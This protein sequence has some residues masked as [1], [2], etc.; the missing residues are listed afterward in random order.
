MIAEAHLRRHLT[1][2]ARSEAERAADRRQKRP[3]HVN[4]EFDIQGSRTCPSGPMCEWLGEP[5]PHLLGLKMSSQIEPAPLTYPPAVVG[6]N[7]DSVA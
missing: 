5:D 1:L 2:P 6:P 7:R 3:A 4:G